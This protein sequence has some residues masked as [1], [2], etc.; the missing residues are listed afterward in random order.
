MIPGS[1][2]Q[3]AFM[4]LLAFF[5]VGLVICFPR[6]RNRRVSLPPPDPQ[7]KRNSVESV[8]P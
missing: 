4:A 6:K 5:L 2:C 3:V 7:C 1:W 8:G